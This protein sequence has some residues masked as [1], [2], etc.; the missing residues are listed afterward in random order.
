MAKNR[1]SRCVNTDPTLTM[2]KG[3]FAMAYHPIPEPC[4]PIQLGEFF[5]EDRRFPAVYFLYHRGEVVYVGQSRTLKLRI[6]QHLSD[7]AKMFDAVAFIPCPFNRLNQLEA[8]YIKH[9]A[10]K[11]NSCGSAKKARDRHGWQGLE[12]HRKDM[13]RSRFTGPAYKPGD[14]IK[15]IDASEVIIAPHELGEF[16]GIT[17]SD[18]AELCKE[19]TDFSIPGIFLFA[20]RNSD[21]VTKAQERFE[22]L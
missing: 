15:T 14:E 9:L 5:T 12:S 1:P 16:L 2:T 6:D 10:P 21:R 3:Y 22:E 17:E 7:M 11:Y 8:H 19:I 13:R 20:V 4:E 18:A